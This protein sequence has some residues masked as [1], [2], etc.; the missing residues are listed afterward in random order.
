M[1]TQSQQQPEQQKPLLEEEDDEQNIEISNQVKQDLNDYAIIKEDERYTKNA[2]QRNLLIAIIL[3]VVIF[4]ICLVGIGLMNNRDSSHSEEI[5]VVEVV[6]EEEEIEPEIIVEEPEEE[7]PEVI[8]APTQEYVVDNGI[9][10]D[11]ILN[12]SGLGMEFITPFLSTNVI[13]LPC[14]YQ[15]F[16]LGTIMGNGA[17]ITNPISEVSPEGETLIFG[18]DEGKT[19]GSIDVVSGKDES[20]PLEEALVTGV[21]FDFSANQK[22]DDLGT[23]YLLSVL[24]SPLLD[25]SSLWQKDG[26]NYIYQ[27]KVD[28]D[29]PYNLYEITIGMPGGIFETFSYAVKK[30]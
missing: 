19:V 9:A 8:E 3:G 28:R 25:N 5:E 7:E 30:G 12:G 17:T 1:S 4:S 23:S 27:Q 21:T 10:M 18:N 24:M 14:E 6:E 20:V 22:E 11:D 2:N 16:A 29:N 26:T 13:S 15:S